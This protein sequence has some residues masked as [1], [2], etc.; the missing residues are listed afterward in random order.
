MEIVLVGLNHKMAPVAVREKVAFTPACMEA[1]LGAL[2]ARTPEGV[3]LSTCNRIE[4]YVAAPSAEAGVKEITAFL[5]G[6]HRLSPDFLTPYLY[7]LSGKEAVR[8]LLS[9]SSGLDSMILGEPQILG[10]VRNAYAASAVQDG[11][12]PL[13]SWVFRHAVKVGKQVRTDTGICRNAVSVSH[14]AVELAKGVF[15]SLSDRAVL[16]VGAGDMGELAARNLLDNG[17]DRLVVSNRTYTRAVQLAAQVGGTAAEFSRMPQLLAEA[18]IA[19]VSTGASS[20]VVTESMVREAMDRRAGRSLFMIDIAVP[21]N[22]DPTVKE[23][24]GCFLH[25]VDDLYNVCAANLEARRNAVA[26]AQAVIDAE[27]EVF[28]SWRH[29]LQVVPTICAL[30]EEA[31]RIRQAELRKSLPRLG[32]LSESQLNALEALTTGMMNKILHKPTVQLKAH[33]NDHFGG[34]YA[35]TLRELFALDESR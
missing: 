4:I 27:V 11:V 5:S 1:A 20:F 12:G 15:G 34:V 18:D 8:H 26:P 28:D 2:H 33:A 16:L 19:I 10:Q 35:R 21:R 30:R 7:N 23:I 14:A 29:G 25:D 24:D 22:V 6:F 32:D 9:V 3:I 31:E 17:A 13:L